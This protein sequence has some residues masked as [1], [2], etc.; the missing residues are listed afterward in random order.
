M[1]EISAEDIVMNLVVN[2]GDAR[3]KAIEAIRAARENHFA[4]ADQLLVDAQEAVNS[5]HHFQTD[6]I[7]G[8]MGGGDPVLV[9]LLM[10]HGQDHLM[11]AMTVMDLAAEIVALNKL[12]HEKGAV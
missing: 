11:N 7:Q 5:A 3:S 4:D 6:L 10:V 1:K 12:L 9:S 8:E 2:G